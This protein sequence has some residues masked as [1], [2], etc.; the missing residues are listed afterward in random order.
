MTNSSL[1]RRAFLKGFGAVSAGI[2][3]PVAA[4]GVTLAKPQGRP[5]TRG[6]EILSWI[7]IHEDNAVTVVVPQTEIGQGVT[8]TLRQMVGEELDL[9]WATM[10][11]AFYD[12]NVNKTRG[13][14][15]VWTATLGSSSAHSLFK[16]SRIAAAQIRAMLIAAAAARLRVAADEL[17][18]ANNVVRHEKS[19]RQ[20]SYAA[21]APAAA[22]LTPPAADAVTLKAP[23]AWT[24]I[25]KPLPQVDTPL[26]TRGA[27]R[28]GID[29]ELPGMRFAA[30]RQSPVFGGK[31]VGI[32]AAKLKGLPGAPRVVTVKGGFVGYNSPVPEGEDPAIW[33]AEVHMDDAVAVVADS[34]WQA[35]TAL[36]ALAITWD[37]GPHAKFSSGAL[38]RK[39]S[40]KVQGELP[41]VLA[42]GDI[43]AAFREAAKTHSAEYTY[44][45]LDPAPLEPLNCTVLVKRDAVQVWAGTQFADDAHELTCKLVNLPP[46]KVHL[47]LVP[48]GGGFGRRLQNDFVHQAVQIGRAMPGVPVKLLWTREECIQRSAYA[49]LSVMKLAA[50]LDARG[51]ISGWRS[52]LATAKSAEQSYGSAR[53][54]F[55]FPAI[56][57]Q[58]HRDEEAPL[59]FGWMRGVGQTQYLW[60][61]Y[62]FFDELAGLA[63]RD[64]VAFIRAHLDPERIPAALEKRDAAVARAQTLRRVLDA[65]VAKAAWGAK[66]PRSG[67]GIVVSD[68]SYYA[69]YESA[70]KV[71]IVDVTLREDG[72]VSVDKV[73]ITIDCGVVINPDIVRRQLEGCVSYALTNAFLSEITVEN[74]RVQQ[75]NFHDYP[76]LKM[77]QVPKIEVNLLPSEDLPTGVGEDAVPITIAALVNAIADAGGPRIRSLPIRAPTLRQAS[78]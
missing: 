18:C 75:S 59:Q 46:E 9:D 43:D 8:T 39:L 16:P 19:G 65:A 14:P 36:E 62:A 21:L 58:Y 69:G 51:M 52:K 44:P 37:E 68:T 45:Y 49:P 6:T 54:Q 38:A 4:H 66:A 2:I 20:L 56:L 61:N 22:K 34:W 41:T 12:P 71:G 35:K 23:D 27:L 42:V 26:M 78:A 40:Q 7:V 11:T 73:A 60:M 10:R 48:C 15:Y 53:F 67:R 77:A 3:F 17:T 70:S 31:L 33:T 28:Y 24:R 57:A 47:H 29:L 32:D 1:A 30:I 13:N 76:I 63:G 72:T 25:G 74:G 55:E 64:R 5:A 50:A